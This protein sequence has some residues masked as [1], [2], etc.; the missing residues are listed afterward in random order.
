MMSVCFHDAKYSHPPE[1]G[2]SPPVEGWLQTLHPKGRKTKF[3]QETRIDSQTMRTCSSDERGD[4]W[5]TPKVS[6]SLLGWTGLENY[7]HKSW[8]V[9]DSIVNNKRLQ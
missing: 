5:T 2:P 3:S 6:P 8:T 9:I 1:E 4:G 7:P